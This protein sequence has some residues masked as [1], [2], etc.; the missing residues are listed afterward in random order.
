MGEAVEK[1]LKGLRE[2]PRRHYEVAEYASGLQ[3][4]AH[5]PM[6]FL[7]VAVLNRSLALTR[8]FCDLIESRN[9]L[10]A[11]P[12]IRLQLDS[13]LRFWA[14]LSVPNPNDVAD[15]ILKGTPVSHL[16]DRDG[17]KMNDGYLKKRLAEKYPWV[18]EVYEHTSGFIHL[19]EKHIFNALRVENREERT[20][21]LKVGE[22]DAFVPEWAYLQAIRGFKEITLLLLGL[23]RAWGEIKRQHSGQPDPDQESVVDPGRT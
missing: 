2:T 7:V 4:G 23:V 18:S 14:A 10:A 17:K 3:S 12:L 13:C 9:F 8:G 6:D 22:E 1:A 5:Y 11:A 16:K 20:V 15:E 21:L 19:S